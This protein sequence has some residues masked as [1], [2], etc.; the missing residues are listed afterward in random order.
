[1]HKDRDLQN[2]YSA[3][4]DYISIILKAVKKF[5][6][7]PN[8]RDMIHDEMIHHL[9]KIRPNYTQDS[10]EAAL[11]DWIYLGRFVGYRSIEWCQKTQKSYHKIEHPN[12]EGPLSYAFIAED[13]QFFNKHKQPI[14]NDIDRISIDDIAYVEIRFRKQKNN[15]NY[16]VIPYYKDELNPAFCPVHAVLR[17]CQRAIRLKVPEEEPVGVFYSTTGKYKNERCFLTADK[18]ATLL[19][20]V[21]AT[22]FNLKKDDKS[23]KRWTSHSI[24][25]TACNL[26]HRQGFS[27]TYIQAQLRWRSNAFLDYLRNTLYTAAKHTKALHIP[28]NNL[29]ILTAARRTTTLPSGDTV[30]SNCPSGTPLQRLRGREEI[31]QV[32]HAGAA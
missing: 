21:A 23:L 1:M 2:I 7:Q 24:R 10:L 28:L 5:E 6:K 14:Y 22:V 26:L 13:F 12:W 4:V 30:H 3:P 19:Q 11:T 9:E 25:V 31:E 15:K 29:P 18:V 32:M 27:D 8:R 17:I 16:E 20:Q